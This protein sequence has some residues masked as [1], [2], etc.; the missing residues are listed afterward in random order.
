MQVPMHLT[1]T[2]VDLTSVEQAM[3]E[4]AVANLERCFARMISCHVAVSVPHH[5][6][7]GVPTAWS[8]R[9]AL[10]VPGRVL[11]VTRQA[12]PSFREALVAAF[13]VAGRELQDDARESRGDG[14]V[15]AEEPHGRISRLRARE[16]FGFITA[17]DGHELYFNRNSVPDGGFDRLV[18]GTEVRLV[19]VEGE[20]G[21]QASMVVAVGSPDSPFPGESGGEA[22]Q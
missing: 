14:W 8:F 18:V 20:Q 21:P 6:P 1:G 10:T 12:R 7:G 4:G 5:L 22:W 19:E 17:D 15:Q 16:G 13:D 9:L 11:T 3:V 2:G